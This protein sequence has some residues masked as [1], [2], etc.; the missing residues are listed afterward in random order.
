M[1]EIL[2][3]ISG[4]TQKSN[5]EGWPMLYKNQPEYQPPEYD[6]IER[7]GE[8]GTVSMN[9]PTAEELAN[10]PEEMSEHAQNAQKQHSH[11]LLQ[12]K[13]GL[14][15][16]DLGMPEYSYIDETGGRE[17]WRNA[18]LSPLPGEER[19][20]EDVRKWADTDRSAGGTGMQRLRAQYLKEVPAKS[21]KLLGFNQW[22]ESEQH[23]VVMNENGEP[24]SEKLDVP[25][26][27][28]ENDFGYRG[29][30]A[31]LNKKAP[32][33]TTE[34]EDPDQAHRAGLRKEKVIS[35]YLQRYGAESVLG[36]GGLSREEAELVYDDAALSAAQ[37]GE[38]P[39]IAAGR[40][41]KGATNG[42]QSSKDAQ[43]RM[44]VDNRTSQNN[45]AQRFGV[46]VGVIATLDQFGDAST[47]EEAQDALMMGAMQYPYLGATMQGD[48]V[49]GPG[50][51]QSLYNQMLAGEISIAQAQADLAKATGKR[52]SSRRR[53]R[54]NKSAGDG[55]R[56]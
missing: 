50:V 37:N 31:A 20:H 2:R 51:F 28:P 30:K 13:D 46:P 43:L 38:N 19:L 5:P 14:S 34:H 15:L 16:A 48:G 44:N 26:F 47:P 32:M 25:T 29:N 27:D 17:S 10:P 22:L 18:D 4:Y 53:K 42:M 56:R 23:R 55:R 41:L 12:N 11:D 21:R 39:V 24:T 8:E 3:N 45:R 6:P 35:S 36:G 9:V 40:A 7:K 1:S 33:P 54:T 52:P 49:Q